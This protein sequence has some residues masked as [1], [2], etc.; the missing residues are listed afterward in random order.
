MKRQPTTL[1]TVLVLTTV[2]VLTL[3]LSGCK[4][5]SETEPEEATDTGS[6]FTQN[7]PEPAPVE[8]VAVA[9]PVQVA[10]T[11]PPVY[12]DFDR[13]EIRS[14]NTDTLK[15]GASPPTSRLSWEQLRFEFTRLDT[16]TGRPHPKRS[17]PCRSLS[18]RR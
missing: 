15:T 1:T 13:S 9:E 11:I 8:P 14:D 7:E 17:W 18:D 12:F 4:S 5:N 2:A 16:R 10:V 3:G 6:E